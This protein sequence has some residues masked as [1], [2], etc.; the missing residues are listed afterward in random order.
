VQPYAVADLMQNLQLTMGANISYGDTG[1]EY[2]GFYIP[3]TGRLVDYANSF[4]F[5]LTYFF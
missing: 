5:W 2:G 1:T 3:G 4:Y